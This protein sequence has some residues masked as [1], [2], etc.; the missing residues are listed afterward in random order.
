MQ[1][2]DYIPFNMIKCHYSVDLTH[3]KGQGR[4]PIN[5]FVAFL[6][7]LRHHTFVLRLSDLQSCGYDLACINLTQ[8]V[9]FS[10]QVYKIGKQSCKNVPTY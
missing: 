3:F 8:I 4:N 6:E 5:N 2:S 7:N 1:I 9:E 10:F